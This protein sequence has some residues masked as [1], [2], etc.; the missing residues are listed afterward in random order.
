MKDNSLLQLRGKIVAKYGTIDN[1]SSAIGMSPVQV[2]K[3][4]NQKAGFSKEDIEKW[5]KILDIAPEDVG[6]CFFMLEK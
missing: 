6:E 3:K 1:F 4:L 5:C 2:S